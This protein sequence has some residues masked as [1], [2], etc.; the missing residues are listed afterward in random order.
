MNTS[1]TSTMATIEIFVTKRVSQVPGKVDNRKGEG[2]GEAGEGKAT[3]K[4]EVGGAK[5]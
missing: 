3:S 5:C 2:E 1:D 4:A